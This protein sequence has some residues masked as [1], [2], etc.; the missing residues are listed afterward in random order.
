MLLCLGEPSVRFLWCCC[1]SFLIFILL[2]YLHLSMF[3][4]LLL[5]F[6]HIFFST[7][8]LT[9]PWTIAGF[10]LPLYT[11]S[12][13]RRRGICDTSIFRLFRYLLAASATALSGH[14]VATNG[15]YLMLLHRHSTCIYQGLLG[16]RQFFLEVYR[17]SYWSSKHRPAPSVCLIHSNPQSSYSERFSFKFYNILSWI[18]YGESLIYLLFTSFE[19]FSLFQSHM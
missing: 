17:A 6:I 5:F 1:S 19:L 10:L 4:I 8:S 11:I 15:S 12:P 16:S 14:F 3:F 2:L 18:A 9:V 7:S 13:A